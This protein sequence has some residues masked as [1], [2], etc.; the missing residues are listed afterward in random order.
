MRSMT[1]TPWELRIISLITCIVAYLW[2]PVIQS[3]PHMDLYMDGGLLVICW[4]FT[5]WVCRGF[6]AYM[7]F[8]ARLIKPLTDKLFGPDLEEE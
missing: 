7:R 1:I 3:D 6:N 4:V 8:I 2:H 5:T